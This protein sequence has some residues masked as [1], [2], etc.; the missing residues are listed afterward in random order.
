MWAAGEGHSDVV[1]VLLEAGADV[2]ARSIAGFYTAAVRDV[3]RGPA[4]VAGVD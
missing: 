4:D 2:N 1:G 3:A